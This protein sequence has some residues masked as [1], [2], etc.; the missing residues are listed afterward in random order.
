[1]GFQRKIQ[2]AALD[3]SGVAAT[4]RPFIAEEIAFATRNVDP[5][6]VDDPCPFNPAGHRFTG[7]C[8]DVVCLHCA[9]I[10]WA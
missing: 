7:S 8:G 3:R 5:F 2:P 4:I 9:R 1:M 10:V 6:L